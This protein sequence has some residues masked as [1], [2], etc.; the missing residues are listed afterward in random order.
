MDSDAQQRLPSVEE[1]PEADVVIYDGQCRFCC[2]QVQRLARWDGA[3]RLA[4]ISLHDPRVAERYP[5]L[6]H[7]QLME[8][9]YVIDR[10]GRRHGG[11]AAL[12]YLSRRLPRLWW[13]APLLHLP[14]T[15]PLWQA[16]YR[17]VARR[18]YLLW[19]RHAQ[20]DNDRC[21]IHFAPQKTNT[22]RS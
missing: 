22:D 19:R 1:L 4:F 20:C 10:H 3:G 21:S 6:S 18:R 9:M 11:A 13:C 14:G 16:L 12:R 17:Y 5:D 8:Q 2:A 7:D 15:L